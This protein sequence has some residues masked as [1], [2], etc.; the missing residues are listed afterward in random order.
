MTRLPGLA[1]LLVACSAARAPGEVTAPPRPALLVSDEGPKRSL[2]AAP[3]SDGP[4]IAAVGD[5]LPSAEGP[6]ALFAHLQSSL[7]RVAAGAAAET[8][9]E[10]LDALVSAYATWMRGDLK[11]ASRQL[12]AAE[13]AALDLLAS[14]LEKWRKGRS[15]QQPPG[16]EPDPEATVRRLQAVAAHAPR[17]PS[18]TL[19]RLLAVMRLVDAAL[20]VSEDE[21][22]L[23]Y[24]FDLD[25]RAALP[26]PRS[27]REHLWLRLP[28]RTVLGRRAAFERATRKVGGPLLGCPTPA[29]REGDFRWMERFAKDPGSLA[30]EAVRVPAIPAPPAPPEL[31]D[32]TPPPKPWSREAA[33]RF[34]D[35]DPDAAEAALAGSAH[36]RHLI[37][38]ALFLHG[39]RPWSPARDT[40][41]AALLDQMDR[42][43][44]ANDL[45]GYPA[46]VLGAPVPYDGTDDSVIRRL[47]RAS[48]A[49][50]GL[51]DVSAYEIPCAVLL[52]RPALREAL[53]PQFGSTRD[54]VLPA[55]GCGEGRVRGFPYAEL[56]AYGA[57]TEEA[58]GHFIANHDGTMRV[59]LARGRNVARTL[60]ELD[61]GSLAGE[62]ARPAEPYETWSYLTLANRATFFRIRALGAALVAKLV[63]FNRARGLSEEAASVA[64]RNALFYGVFGPECEAPPQPSLRKLLLDGASA[65]DIQRFIAS[66]QHLLPER[67]APFVSCRAP[68][69]PL[70]HVALANPAALDALWRAGTALGQERAAALD[71]AVDVNVRN[72]LGKTPLMTAAQFAHVESAQWL[73]EHGAEVGAVTWSDTE[74]LAH[75]GRTALMYAAASGSLN[76]LRLLLAAGADPHRTDTRGVTPLGYLLG[77]GPVGPNE[78][79]SPA[80]RGEAARLLF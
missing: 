22:L 48:Q 13:A 25:T 28:C 60:L 2:S 32:E 39:F 29:G 50:S 80:E 55:S 77:H 67:L 20:L 6:R 11:T 10:P 5:A 21:D 71:L 23:R 31:G 27:H 59:G 56:A 35:V 57:A 30:H 16:S 63:P 1:L 72:A 37:D 41:I 43:V 69:D 17:D 36:A 68:L 51:E 52:A 70:L 49:N 14:A 3:N 73:L 61:P 8:E 19:L 45:E 34:M 18:G 40:R 47:R 64:A 26:Y 33:L 54:A 15:A 79:L 38:F 62:A 7:E 58:D 53:Q 74:P 66:G 76:M 9:D 42:L 24:G 65:S 46:E 44:G 75:D 78:R 12:D 4:P